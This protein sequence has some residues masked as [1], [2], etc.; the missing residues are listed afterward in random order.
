MSGF[1][2]ELAVQQAVLRRDFWPAALSFWFSPVVVSLHP[3]S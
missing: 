2:R 3:H 1:C